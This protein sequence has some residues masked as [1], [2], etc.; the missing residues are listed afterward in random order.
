MMNRFLIARPGH[1]YLASYNR[2][3]NSFSVDHDLK[4]PGCPSWLAVDRARSLV[5]IVDEDSTQFHRFKLDA[6]SDTPFTQKLTVE[7]ASPGVVYLAFSQ[8]MTRM[9]GAAF[10]N[11][12][13]D[14]WDITDGEKLDKLA[15]K[16]VTS[17]G[18]TGPVTHIQDGPHPHQVILDPTGRFYVVNDMG[19]DEILVIDSKDEAYSLCNRVSVDPAGSGPRHGA[20]YPVGAS[21]PTHY[22]LLCE[23]RNK[24]VVYSLKYTESR[25]EFTAVSEVSSFG[26]AGPSVATARAG[27][28]E[29]LQ[30]NRDIYVTNRLT[31][32]EHDTVAHVRVR[33]TGEH[34][35]LEFVSEVPT[36]GIL[37]RM[38]CVMD[39]GKGDILAA[40][41]KSP[42][43]LVM[44]ERDADGRLDP[45][46]KLCVPMIDF[47]SEQEMKDHP[48][49]GP[50]FIL[51]L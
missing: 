23:L 25:L 6:A 42:L 28:L 31:E 1:V 48:G 30:N 13:V 24:V 10:G 38:F 2:V 51:E 50:K 7:I 43:A 12:T 29:L 41:E 45:T 44:L 26:P 19:T 36:L 4:I 46:P 18:K 11:S 15:D 5:Y 14:I 27:H 17:D 22:I 39:G 47:M 16:T 20:F 49:N 9:L 3:T 21:R 35:E 33:Q 37:P 40:N 32:R 34:P 8:D